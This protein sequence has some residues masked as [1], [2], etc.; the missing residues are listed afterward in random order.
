[1]VPAALCQGYLDSLTRTVGS[2]SVALVDIRKFREMEA[3]V[4]LG[5][6]P[7]PTPFIA[8]L[9]DTVAKRE[10]I[11]SSMVGCHWDLV[12][13]DE[14]H[15]LTG[16][17]LSVVER[18]IREGVVSR[19]LFM[20]ATPTKVL[21]CIGGQE[22]CRTEWGDEDE[23]DWL[24]HSLRPPE[25]EQ[26]LLKLERTREEIQFLEALES[27]L[28]L[29]TI[30]KSKTA[31]FLKDA[32][33]QKAA[34]SVFVLEEALGRLG[35]IR[36]DIVHG[37]T[38]ACSQDLF[39]A[40]SDWEE[41]VGDDLELMGVVQDFVGGQNLL[42]LIDEIRSDQKLETLYQLLKELTNEENGVHRRICIF[43][44]YVDTVLYLESSLSDVG[45]NVTSLTGSTSP[46]ER[47]GFIQIL[48]ESNKPLVLVTSITEGTDFRDMDVLI[49]YDF[50]AVQAQMEQRRGRFN[51]LGR[52][53]PFKEFAFRD[54]S[55][56]LQFEDNLL[57]IYFPTLF[58]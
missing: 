45:Y 53:K 58:V 27:F 2:D 10:Q 49:H 56:V 57:R 7:W 13:V 31:N 24:G 25:P 32:L 34:S 5:A 17:S 36:N 40:I 12:V 33:L 9:S 26:V 14:A 4:G 39:G 51:R 28:N 42:D 44:S 50:P 20:T 52:T 3:N 18:M 16:R 1:M 30:T 37:R 6:S 47:T 23:I 19:T 41:E 11:S 55:G 8:I 54:K 29:M 22:L 35:R 43:S 46:E 48:N 15:R 21:L 38:V